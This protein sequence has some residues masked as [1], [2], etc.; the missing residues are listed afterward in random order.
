VVGTIDTAL[1]ELRDA[2]M[3]VLAGMRAGIEVGK[4]GSK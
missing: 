1:A 3:P 4:N 2:A